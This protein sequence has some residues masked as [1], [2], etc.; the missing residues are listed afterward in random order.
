MTRA[1]PPFLPELAAVP[2]AGPIHH[3]KDVLAHTLA[4]VAKTS[5]R[6]MCAWP[7]HDVSPRPARSATAG[8]FRTTSGGHGGRMQAL[9]YA[10][11]DVEAVLSSCTSTCFHTYG[12]GR[13]DAAV[14][15]FVLS[16]D[17]LDDLIELTRCDVTTRNKRRPTACG[18]WTSGAAHRGPAGRGAGETIRPDLDG[19]Q[20]TPPG[21]RLIATSARRSAAFELRLDEG[22]WVGGVPPSR[23]MVGD[24]Q[25]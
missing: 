15:R 2:R 24:Q 25:G 22:P 7:S 16:R 21:H 9:K 10:N 19:R 3:H 23:Q 11:D 20:V 6:R 18:A 12:M 5:P 13:T 4:V 14:R 8:P 17:Q 1:W